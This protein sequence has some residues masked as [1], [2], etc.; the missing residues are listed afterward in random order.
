MRRSDSW[1]LILGV[2]L[3][4]IGSVLLLNN[5]GVT[6]VDLSYIIS[7]FWP[8]LI[9]GLGL[10]WV[11]KPDGSESGE[12]GEAE[13]QATSEM[14]TSSVEPEPVDGEGCDE[15]VEDAGEADADSPRL[16]EV[17]TE[18]S[19][20]QEDVRS[21]A[22]YDWGADTV[23]VADCQR[24]GGPANGGED[25]AELMRRRSAMGWIIAILG[26]LILGSKM[27]RSPWSTGYAGG[28]FW[29]IVAIFIGLAMVRSSGEPAP[30]GK[31]NWAVLSRI[32]HGQPGLE[33]RSSSYMAIL[34]SVVLDLSAS[35]IPDEETRLDIT[36]VLGCVHVV[37]PP[38]LSVKCEGTAVLGNVEAF[39]HSACGGL[40]NRDFVRSVPGGSSKSLHIKC[41]SILGSIDIR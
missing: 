10:Y 31:T 36:A 16:T 12:V 13:R 25:E 23:D 3:M 35:R 15:C 41:R 32:D 28:V 7:N 14:P 17:H 21:E 29:A 18:E 6:S 24:E 37:L 20:P 40:V 4:V 19:G 8:L 1:T 30:E 34:G 26:L 27:G 33:L 22:T 9:V 2:V 5:L 39:G 38:E 11:L